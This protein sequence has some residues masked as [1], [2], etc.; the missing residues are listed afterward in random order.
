MPRFSI[1]VHY[2]RWD[3]FGSSPL[4]SGQK[5]VDDKIIIRK[6]T[7]KFDYSTCGYAS[8]DVG[9]KTRTARNPKGWTRSALR[10]QIRKDMET[11]DRQ[12]Q[13]WGHYLD[14]I[15]IEGLVYNPTKGTLIVEM[16]S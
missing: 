6:R 13:V 16:G 4:L 3:D 8:D 14:Q 1:D 12:N 9:F 10:T 15:F 11:L 2:D 7:L 5:V